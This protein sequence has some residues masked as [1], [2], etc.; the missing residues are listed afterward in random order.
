[1]EQC[2]VRW[3]HWEAPATHS[4][5]AVNYVNPDY[6]QR[7]VKFLVLDECRLTLGETLQVLREVALLPQNLFTRYRHGPFGA[8]SNSKESKVSVVGLTEH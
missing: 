4:T 3:S 7:I 6:S 2:H 1:M 8:S 5:V